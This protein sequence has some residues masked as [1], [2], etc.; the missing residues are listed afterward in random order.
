MSTRMEINSG[1]IVYF[2]ILLIA[3]I[4]L[5]FININDIKLSYFIIKQYTVCILRYA[6]SIIA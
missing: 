2:R 3:R 6:D 1:D 4:S 5:Y